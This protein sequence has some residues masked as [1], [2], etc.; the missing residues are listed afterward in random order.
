MEHSLW[1]HH[2]GNSR[3]NAKFKACL[4]HNPSSQGNLS[5]LSHTNSIPTVY[6]AF[7]STLATSL[8]ESK[9]G[10]ACEDRPEL[11]KNTFKI[12]KERKP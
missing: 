7:C 9:A 5:R 4:S 3:K 6:R 12:P 11:E 2:S 1:S 8:W 10:A